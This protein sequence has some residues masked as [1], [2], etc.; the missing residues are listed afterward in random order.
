M[1]RQLMLTK[2]ITGLRES[3]AA[4]GEEES[5]LQTRSEELEKAI[6]EAS[7]DEELQAVEESITELE[8]EKAKLNEK[9]SKL[10]SEIAELEGEL[11]ELKSKA[12]PVSGGAKQRSG[13]QVKDDREREELRA[14]IAA[15]VRSKGRVIRNGEGE[16]DSGFKVV[17]GGALVPEDLLPP[18]ETP[19]DIVDLKNYV[20]VVSVNRG[21]GK[22]P[23]ISKSGSRMNTVAELEAN[24]ELQKP[25][26]T[27]KEYS[28]DTYRG[29]IP[30][31]QEVIDDADYDI[32]GLIG[33]E[34]ND[35]KRNT[36]NYAIAQILKSATAKTVNGLD[37]LITLLN[38]GFKTAYD[39]KLFVSQS[40]FNEL[41]LM[42]DKRGRY[43]LQDDITVASG[44]RL[45]GKEIVIL[46]DEMI[47]ESPGD[48][49]GF[50]GDARAF[51]RFFDRKQLSVKWVD[52]SVYGEMLAGFL[53]FDVIEADSEA[54]Y[55]I[56]FVPDDGN[57]EDNGGEEV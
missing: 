29:Y 56:T 22:Y 28:I 42:K 23:I 24:P 1:L 3:L 50:I 25:Q 16:G 54:G 11:E 44:K 45:K 43:L 7:T 35:Q 14:A 47:G 36:T 48:L 31:S 9:K 10:E 30:V 51:V 49:V 40:L 26:V 18:E 13:D 55:Y 2:K 8:A 53:R 21:S 34:I 57:G 15:F 6:E 5:A 38:T 27:E 39:V 12:P 19:E 52:H 46:D 4:L 32:V 37:G 20:R 17:D 41:D 33:E